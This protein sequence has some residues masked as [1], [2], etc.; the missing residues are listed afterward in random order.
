MQ[1]LENFNFQFAKNLRD[2]L[3]D[4]YN[5][6]PMTDGNWSVLERF[7]DNE[8]E[9]LEDVEDPCECCNCPEIDELEDQVFEAK[10]A[11]NSLKDEAHEALK[12]AIDFLSTEK[13]DESKK[14][15]ILEDLKKAS[16]QIDYSDIW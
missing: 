6:D 9:K 15:N 12:I 14:Q 1:T 11:Y 3:Q 2:F 16:N 8:L 10:S 5:I 7:V 4:T 13:I